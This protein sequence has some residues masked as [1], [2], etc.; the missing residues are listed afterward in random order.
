MSWLFG[1][2]QA[3]VPPMPDNYN[4]QGA[5]QGGPEGAGGPQGAAGPG[6]K[7]AY[8]FD[9]TALER[10]AKA[11]RDLEKFPNAKVRRKKGIRRVRGEY[12]RKHWS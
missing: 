9:S 4:P 7:M 12:C 1:M 2:K 6:S 5:G 8:S 3:E 10:A 11:A